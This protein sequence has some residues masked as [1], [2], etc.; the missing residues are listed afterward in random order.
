MTAMIHRTSSMLAVESDKQELDVAN[1]N[2]SNSI[3]ERSNEK[4][5]SKSET[6]TVSGH[7][8]HVRRAPPLKKDNS[9]CMTMDNAVSLM[10]KKRVDEKLPNDEWKK[11][12]TLDKEESRVVFPRQIFATV[13]E[14]IQ[15]NSL[16]TARSNLTIDDNS[17]I[18]NQNMTKLLL[19]YEVPSKRYSTN[20]ESVS[21]L[22]PPQA[23]EESLE[24]ASAS[25]SEKLNPES[26]LPRT[27]GAASLFPMFA[28]FFPVCAR[29]RYRVKEAD[30]GSVTSK[31][32]MTVGEL[33]S[34]VNSVSTKNSENT[35]AAELTDS[36]IK[37][38]ICWLSAADALPRG[39]CCRRFDGRLNE[40]YCRHVSSLQN[41]PSHP[42]LWAILYA[43]RDQSQ[44][45]WRIQKQLALAAL[46]CYLSPC[47]LVRSIRC[48]GPSLRRLASSMVSDDPRSTSVITGQTNV[49][50]AVLL[51]SPPAGRLFRHS[52]LQLLASLSLVLNIAQ[53]SLVVLQ[54]LS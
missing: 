9:S 11:G 36:E 13:F 2:T 27:E 31:L 30:D 17:V 24:V 26:D 38:E 35:I 42:D 33:N 47:R 51:V 32:M 14:R 7:V 4:C 23:S 18:S 45:I 1:R 28:K 21:Y 22:L 10:A 46:S 16:S 50:A 29:S 34:A 25:G 40:I 52:R 6:R 41:G 39:D 15:G 48:H 53:N 3:A 49:A 37:S 20:D 44:A 8:R 5:R 43:S 12:V 54:P 19:G